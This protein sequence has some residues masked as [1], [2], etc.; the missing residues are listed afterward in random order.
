[1]SKT[2]QLKKLKED[3]HYAL[4]KFNWGASALD[5]DAI[6]I[7][8]EY[9][10]KLDEL[11]VQS[12]DVNKIRWRLINMFNNAFED[13]ESGEELRNEHLAED[14]VNQIMPDIEALQ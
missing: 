3:L 1:M 6:R 8:N 5:A 10:K 7:L 12:A 2:E 11:I 14:Y 4:G 9:P 13:G